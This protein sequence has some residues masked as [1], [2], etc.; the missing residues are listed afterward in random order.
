MKK[1]ITGLILI[2]I[3]AISGCNNDNSSSQVNSSLPINYRSEVKE[4]VDQ[5]LLDELEGAFYFFYETAVSD[6]Y[7]PAYGLIPDRYHT[8]LDRRGDVAS[9]AS[10][11]FGLSMLPVGV[12]YGWIT[13]EE[14][15]NRAYKTLITL[16]NLER[17]H[18]FYYHFLSMS[19]GKRVWNSEV[20]VIDTAILING[21]LTV[22]KY[23]GGDLEKKANK[24]YE[25]VEWNWYFDENTYRFYMSYKPESGFSGSWSGYAEQLMIFVLAAG[26]PTYKVDKS[27]YLNMKFSSTKSSKT[28]A[29]DSF[30]LTWT[31]SLFTYQFSH[32]W[33]DFRD[34]EDEKGVNWFDNSV[35][36]TKAAIEFAKLYSDRYKT[37]HENSW[38]LSASDGPNGYV[39]PYGSAPNSGFANVVDGTVPPYGAL[40]S[41][42]FTPEESINAAKYYR[43]YE[44]LWSKYGFKDAYNLG[45]VD[46]FED[47]SIKGKIPEG[48]WFATD[49]IGID[50]GISALMIENYISSF[51]WNIYMDIDY[52]KD[53][54]NELG[55][56]QMN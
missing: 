44:K 18:G 32:A 29:Y 45:V 4:D 30:Y 50:K 38:G 13:Y 12:E 9:I 7:S 39:G 8:H 6:E 41:I 14:G 52:V 24:L 51:I 3:L 53:G 48:G 17:T 40:G 5:L 22:G 43:T 10:V 20:S 42:V 19:N 46:G 56:K 37:L 25:E 15:Y 27:A 1:K 35:N 28:D 36:A 54:L 16:E 31:G 23:F 49:I 2:L 33:I 26:S 21:V 34:I 55:F 47:T 11:G